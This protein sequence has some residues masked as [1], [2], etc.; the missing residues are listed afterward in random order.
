[1]STKEQLKKELD[2]IIEKRNS[3]AKSYEE[4]EIQL[5]KYD[6]SELENMMELIGAIPIETRELVFSKDTLEMFEKIK[7]AVDQFKASCDDGIKKIHRLRERCNRKT[8]NIAVI[9]AIGAGKSKF[10]Q[11]LS[12]LNDSCIPSFYGESCTGVTSII[13]NVEGMDTQAIFTF[14]SEEEMIADINNEIKK[15]YR[16]IDSGESPTL[17]KRLDKE[18]LRRIFDDL[19]SK[20]KRMDLDGNSR[21]KKEKSLAEC[22][23]VYVDN[24]SEWFPYVGISDKQ[25]V[26]TDK[27][28]KPYEEHREKKKYV[29]RQPELIEQYVAKHGSSTDNRYYRYAAIKE[30]VIQTGFEG[31]D[32]RIRLIDTVGI[33]DPSADTK[34]RLEDAIQNKSDAV[35]FILRGDDRTGDPTI[36]NDEKL[37][38]ELQEIYDKNKNMKYWLA[39]LINQKV[40]ESGGKED[41]RG[42]LMRHLNTLKSYNGK[43]LGE[44]EGIKLQRVVDVKDLDEVTTL[45]YDFL[46]QIKGR[47]PKLDEDLAYEA[48]EKIR[49]IH[50][51]KEELD[52][53][54]QVIK[55]VRYDVNMRNPVSIFVN[56]G[57]RKLRQELKNLKIEVK[58]ESLIKERLELVR[59]IKDE[60]D[61]LGVFKSLDSIIESCAEN[62]KE[63]SIISLMA[64]EQLSQEVRRIGAMPAKFQ[65]QTERE[66]KQKV[67][68]IFNTC[69][70]IEAEALSDDLNIYHEHYFKKLADIL[71]GNYTEP[72]AKDLTERFY[73]LDR[74]KLDDSSGIVK[75]L[76]NHG[77]AVYLNSDTR[78]EEGDSSMREKETYEDESMSKPFYLINRNS[79]VKEKPSED[80]FKE[81]AEFKKKLKAKLKAGLEGFIHEI[82]KVFD[83]NGKEKYRV[84][85]SAQIS[86]ETDNFM[87]GLEKMYSGVWVNV[88]G[89][90][91]DKGVI[92]QEEK[93]KIDEMQDTLEKIREHI[94]HYLLLLE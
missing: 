49:E 73:S 39:F 81:E 22:R 34:M 48:E 92:L 11:T 14:K 42:W 38:K 35:I 21:P 7:K 54:V 88:F 71:F 75:A 60:K 78:Y 69:M 46:Q 66:Y 91:C 40:T 15:L 59:N 1:M 41:H 32:A 72:F 13:E 67:A 85:P 84:E 56:E 87:I 94:D 77:A 76:F 57:I 30:A 24:W 62:S 68:D 55:I 83:E 52:Q 86:D 58:F 8:I 51:K 80:K 31:I 27:Y 20:L 10:L 2:E 90:L 79:S 5:T 74:F 9:G 50:A 64:F 16:T 29:L 26:L 23:E 89:D 53:L 43:L 36:E 18:E 65:G 63:E 3:K 4:K 82:E 45:L 19:R 44:E 6:V 47:L 61:G 93:K 37:L 33:G 70:G 17:I 12:G 28:L 25:I